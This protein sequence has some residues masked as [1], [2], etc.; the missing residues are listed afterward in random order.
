MG[1]SQALVGCAL[2]AKV[3]GSMGEHERDYDDD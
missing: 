2:T 3:V 1:K